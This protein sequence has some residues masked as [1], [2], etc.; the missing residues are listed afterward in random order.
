MIREAQAMNPHEKITYSVDL[1]PDLYG[2]RASGQN[3]I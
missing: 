2:I 1:M 3:T